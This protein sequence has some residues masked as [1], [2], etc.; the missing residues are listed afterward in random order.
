[1]G[2]NS[3]HLNYLSY[4]QKECESILNGDLRFYMT[5][6][7]STLLGTSCQNQTSDYF[8]CVCSS[9]SMTFVGFKWP[10]KAQSSL[11]PS[12]AFDIFN[13]VM[14][15][16]KVPICLAQYCQKRPGCCAKEYDKKMAL[17][18]RKLISTS[19][20]DLCSLNF[21]KKGL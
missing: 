14:R 3:P 12:Q 13:S 1:M 21:V 6:Y 17:A 8:S 11:E 2:N 15:E 16:V 5:L 19:H 20:N 9:P 18:S 10:S 7:L 4:Y